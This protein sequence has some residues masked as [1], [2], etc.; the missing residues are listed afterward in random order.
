MI[1]GLGTITAGQLPVIPNSALSSGRKLDLN[2]VQQGVNIAQTVASIFKRS[3]SPSAAPA[4]YT[5]PPAAPTQK[6]GMNWL[7]VGGV[8]AGLVLA[9]Y[10][11]IRFSKK[12]KAKSLNG[13]SAAPK[14][15]KRVKTAKK[16]KKT[17]YKK[18]NLS[19]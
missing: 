9:T 8:G 3:P 13:V 5:P 7:V 1:D 15:K 17:V 18:V 16:V 12:K 11:A 4:A 10:A 2:K 14:A 6:K 19:V